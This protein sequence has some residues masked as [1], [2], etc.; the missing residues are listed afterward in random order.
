MKVLM[1]SLSGP[2]HD[3]HA[4]EPEGIEGRKNLRRNVVVIQERL[5]KVKIFHRSSIS[6]DGTLDEVREGNSYQDLFVLSQVSHSQRRDRQL[7]IDTEEYEYLF[8]E[9]HPGPPFLQG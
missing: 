9:N 1:V 8:I 3:G 4:G 6:C 2:F 5:E 7:F